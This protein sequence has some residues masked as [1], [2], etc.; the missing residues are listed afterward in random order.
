MISLW[1]LLFWSLTNQSIVTSFSGNIFQTSR[2]SPFQRFLIKENLRAIKL[3]V[4]MMSESGDAEKAVCAKRAPIAVP[5][6]EGKSYW[7]CTCGR[8]KK[9][10]FCDGTHKGI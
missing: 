5:V 2:R 6:E 9:Q 4:R 10:P 7:W 1:I 3:N 8:S